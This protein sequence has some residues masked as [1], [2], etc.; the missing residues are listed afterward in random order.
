MAWIV[1]YALFFF[2]FT[3]PN[4]NPMRRVDVWIELPD[5]LWSNVVGA[6]KA[7]LSSW[8]NLM[9]RLD[10]IAVAAAIWL[11]SWAIG[12]LSL[13]ALRIPLPSR[14]AERCVFACGVGL[15]AVSLLTLGCGLAGWL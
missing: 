12:S 4:S 13:R 8:A 3:L 2:S 14:I 6:P 11:G 7:P 10:L 9:Q 1:G 15:S 5:I